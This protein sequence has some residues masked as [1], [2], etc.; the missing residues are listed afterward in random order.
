M[1]VCMHACMY[2]CACICVCVYITSPEGTKVF[3]A[4]CSCQFGSVAQCSHEVGFRPTV[5]LQM[6]HA[7]FK[8]PLLSNA[9]VK[10]AQLQAA[11]AASLEGADAVAG[12]EPEME[13]DIA[14]LVVRAQ[15][16]VIHNVTIHDSA[17]GSPA[18][19]APRHGGAKARGR[20]AYISMQRVEAASVGSAGV[21]GAP[22]LLWN[23]APVLGAAAAT[24][25]EPEERHR[26]L[27]RRGFPGRGGSSPRR[28]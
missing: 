27:L 10:K 4:P 16:I 12:P 13:P 7:G 9:D 26:P 17:R 15:S 11:L 18:T 20:V 24:G 25:P 2:V 5:L 21:S 8:E 23:G 22:A 14:P 1:F 28:G 3:G 6:S 19:E